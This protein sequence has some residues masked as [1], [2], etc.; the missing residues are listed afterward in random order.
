MCSKKSINWSKI[1]ISTWNSIGGKTVKSVLTI[2]SKKLTRELANKAE[3]SSEQTK[4]ITDT[5]AD[6]I[7]YIITQKVNKQHIDGIYVSEMLQSN[8]IP[9]IAN[10][11]SNNPK[12]RE[13]VQI[14]SSHV[15]EITTNDITV[16]IME[17]FADNEI[18]EQLQF[19][20]NQIA[21]LNSAEEI[22]EKDI[23]EDAD[24]LEEE[25]IE[26]IPT[27]TIE[28]I[29]IENE[30]PHVTEDMTDAEDEQFVNDVIANVRLDFSSSQAALESFD[31]FISVAGEVA[32]FAELQETKRTQIC[33]NA[34]VAI[35]KVEA[36]RDVLQEYLA[37]SFD[38]RSSIF[39]KHFEVVDQALINGDSA[40]LSVG[41]NAINELAASSPFK[42]L[43]DLNTVQQ[44]LI[45]DEE[46]EFDI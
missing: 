27:E 24:T 17:Q 13:I 8:L 3:V 18:L 44:M 40:M 34:E 23:C 28:E 41:L 16:T 43:S 46:N 30:V 37:K 9:A 7:S 42:A 36:M 19:T 22:V 20:A 35:K 32:K 26:E 5:L 6:C 33:S 25:S 38:E 1:G 4:E 45:A 21:A 10:I 11:A 29:E 14:I 15:L 12:G 31:K 2:A 39:A